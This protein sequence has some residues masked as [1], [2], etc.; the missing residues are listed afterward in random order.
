MRFERRALAPPILN[1]TQR[2]QVIG[3]PAGL[4]KT[5]VVYVQTRRNLTNEDFVGEAVY[6]PNTAGYTYLAITVLAFGAS[7]QKAPCRGSHAQATQFCLK[8]V[9]EFSAAYASRSVSV[10]CAP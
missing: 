10:S 1:R 6:A 3:I 7:I 5:E 4:V 9:H 2:A 8:R